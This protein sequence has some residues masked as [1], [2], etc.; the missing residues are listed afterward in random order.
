MLKE[1]DIRHYIL[2]NLL[3]EVPGLNRHLFVREIQK[4]VPSIKAADI[5]YAERFGGLRPQLIDKPSGKLR[6]GEAKI[7]N[8]AG[9]I[10][11]M[12][13]SP[14]G[15]SCLGSGETDMRSIAAHLG[16]RI[17]EQALACELLMG[18]EDTRGR[19]DED[20]LEAEPTETLALAEAV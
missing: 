11:N 1:R 3:Y 9:L 20:G 15:T 7:T 5:S 12:T 19:V 2:R 14:G 17:D 13:P 16:A 6:M 18:Y 10:F 4:I 8:G